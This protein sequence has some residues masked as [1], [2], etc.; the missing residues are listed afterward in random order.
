MAEQISGTEE[1]VVI[2]RHHLRQTISHWGYDKTIA[3]TLLQ[4]YD[5]LTFWD[6]IL[7]VL[8]ELQT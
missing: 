5:D 1:S 8:G 2:H 3:R 7:R 6:M 4:A